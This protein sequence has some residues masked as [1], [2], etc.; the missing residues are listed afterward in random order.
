MNVI[1]LPKKEIEKILALL[2]FNKME[3]DTLLNINMNYIKMNI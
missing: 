1:N 3:I 2:P